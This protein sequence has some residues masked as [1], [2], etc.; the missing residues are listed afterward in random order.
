[1]NELENAALTKG[2]GREIQPRQ[3]DTIPTRILQAPQSYRVKEPLSPQ[4]ATRRPYNSR[5]G[6]ETHD[7]VLLETMPRYAF[8]I[9]G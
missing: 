9:D 7:Q 5:S 4:P 8:L 6:P 2:P 3:A 1:M